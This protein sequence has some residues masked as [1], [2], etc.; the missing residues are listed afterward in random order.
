[1]L[2]A[3]TGA[4]T[5]SGIA[6]LLF[7]GSQKAYFG[8]IFDFKVTP[9]LVGLGVAWALVIAMLGGLLPAIRAARLPIVEALRA[10]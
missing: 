8:I 6:W 5:G 3:L 7:N 10:S 9:G 4:L 1:L 2:L